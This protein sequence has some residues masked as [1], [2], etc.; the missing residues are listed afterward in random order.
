MASAQ[1]VILPYGQ[2][3]GIA[4]QPLQVIDTQ[5]ASNAESTANIGF[6]YGVKPGTN[7]REALLPTTGCKFAGVVLN[8]HVNAP[9]TFGSIDQTSAVPG[10][11]PDTMMELLTEGRCY[12]AVDP[13]TT[14]GVDVR[15]YL[16]YQTAGNSVQGRF[17]DTDNGNVVDVTKQIVFKGLPF[18]A[19]SVLTG[20]TEYICEAYVSI[21]NAP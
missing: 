11:I 15:G 21:S 3:Y 4:G 8:E 6:G 5:S 10:L 20:T 13:D 1:S 16:C 17:R 14:A 7:V 12:V 9:G 2:P 18:R 19:A